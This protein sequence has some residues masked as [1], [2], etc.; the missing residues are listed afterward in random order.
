MKR[1]AAVRTARPK[2]VAQWHKT[3]TDVPM[4]GSVFEYDSTQICDFTVHGL[5][6]HYMHRSLV[7]AAERGIG[8]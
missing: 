3:Q 8:R 4:V 6:E 7:S 2:T 5:P 1:S